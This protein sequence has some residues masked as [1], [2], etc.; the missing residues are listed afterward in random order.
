VERRGRRTVPLA[1]FEYHGAIVVVEMTTDEIVFVHPGAKTENE[2][3]S[4]PASPC[5]PSESP[6]DCAVRIVRE[7]TGLEVTIEGEFTT[8]IQEGTPTGTMYTHGYLA[9][10]TGG[11][12]AASG[13][14]GPVS[15]HRVGEL[16]PLIPVRAAVR[17]VLD[18]YLDLHDSVELRG[19]DH[20]DS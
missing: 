3:A 13:A 11:I 19:G 14:D 7:M 12:L 5:P 10:P 20:G 15:R 4:L 6:R 1:D 2:P 16:P 17:R 8:F 18:A 9:R